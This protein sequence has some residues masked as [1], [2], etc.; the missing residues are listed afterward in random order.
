MT[1]LDLPGLRVSCLYAPQLGGIQFWVADRTMTGFRYAKLELE[2]E[3][4]DSAVWKEP[5]FY[6]S[7]EQAT[8]LINELWTAGI[9]PTSIGDQGETVSAVKAHLE[10]MRRIAFD[11]LNVRE[12]EDEE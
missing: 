6:L 12:N 1:S 3:T 5:S 9:R 8:I 11:F 4:A 10:D 7:R 2:E